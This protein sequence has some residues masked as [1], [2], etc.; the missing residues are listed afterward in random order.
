MLPF[1][2]PLPINSITLSGNYNASNIALIWK[3]IGELN[4][5]RYEIERSNNAVDFSPLGN[6]GSRGNGDNNYGF[7]DLLT[8]FTGSNVY[9]R[10]KIVDADGRVKYSNLL[11]MSLSGIKKLIV[12]PNPF[13]DVLNIQVTSVE[14]TNANIRLINSGGQE[15]ARVSQSFVTGLN[16]VQVTGL[17]QVTGRKTL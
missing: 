6:V 12:L 7:D 1:F 14:N 4:V 17:E 8:S 16:S 11:R 9:Y 13:N 3:V 10:I 15:V 5:A 2:T